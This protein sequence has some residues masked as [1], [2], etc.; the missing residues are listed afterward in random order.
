MEDS[1]NFYCYSF[2]LFHFLSAFSEKCFDSRINKNTGKRYWVFHKSRR[3][4][5]IISAY[6]EMK[7]RFN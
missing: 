1:S 3:L 4:D 6:N 5:E 7:H 2:K